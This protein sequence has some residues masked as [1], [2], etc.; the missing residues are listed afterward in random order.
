MG[1]CDTPLQKTAERFKISSQIDQQKA[2]IQHPKIISPA[3]NPTPKK[4]S[5]VHCPL[6][7]LNYPLPIAR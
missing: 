4:L 3:E 7:I 6:S 2:R 1:V 5:I